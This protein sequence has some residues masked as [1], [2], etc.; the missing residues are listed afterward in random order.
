MIDVR[1]SAI[2]IMNGMKSITWNN[3]NRDKLCTENDTDVGSKRVV[4]KAKERRKI[5]KCPAS[6]S[7]RPILS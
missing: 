4:F 2:T 3:S 6:T 1:R 5:T 7:N